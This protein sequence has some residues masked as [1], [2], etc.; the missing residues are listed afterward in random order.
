MAEHKN[1]QINEL[2][3]GGTNYKN[4]L[5]HNK[6]YVY[7][8]QIKFALNMSCEGRRADAPCRST[9]QATLGDGAR[10]ALRDDS[11]RKNE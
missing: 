6:I 7:S 11:L 8:K 10:T 2:C 4:S 5:D 1:F 3:C 9:E